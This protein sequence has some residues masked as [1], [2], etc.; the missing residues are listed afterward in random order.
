VQCPNCSCIHGEKRGNQPPGEMNHTTLHDRLP[1][2]EDCGTIVITYSIFPGVQGMNHPCPGKPY[3]VKGFPKKCYLP[4]N[5]KGK[6]VSTGFFYFS[7]VSPSL[8]FLDSAQILDHLN[9]ALDFCWLF[10]FQ[11]FESFETLAP[12]NLPYHAFERGYK[13]IK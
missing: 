9:L 2:H 11:I 8:L 13:L 7:C 1:G 12:A 4:N 6:R 10:K 5:Q 3:I